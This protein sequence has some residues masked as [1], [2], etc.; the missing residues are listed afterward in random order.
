M[1][2][3]AAALGGC[4][5]DTSQ[6]AAGGGAIVER[7]WFHPSV[8]H[9]AP[10]LADVGWR[11]VALPDY[12]GLARRSR[13][14]SGWY[15]IE[16]ARP[17]GAGPWAASLHGDWQSLEVEIG[18]QRLLSAD[19]PSSQLGDRHAGV[20]LPLLD[21]AGGGR[22]ITL[23]FETAP[24]R[25]GYLERAVIGP[26]EAVVALHDRLAMLQPTLRTSFAALAAACGLLLALLARW[27]PT[28]GA[29]WFAA[30]TIV[31]S[32][33]FLQPSAWLTH[34]GDGFVASF[35]VHVFPL[36]FVIGLHR[37]LALAR[38][39]R[40]RALAVALL[41]PGVVRLAVPPVLVPLVDGIWWLVPLGIGFYLL[42]LIAVA[43]KEG[44]VERSRVLFVGTVVC[45]AAGIHDLASLP[46][47]GAPAGIFL[48]QFAPGVLA[49]CTAAMLLASLGWRLGEA[50]R[51]NV[52]LED[53]V[54]ARRR[55]LASSYARMAELEGDRAIA[56]ER[57]RLMRDMHDGTGGAL[58]SAIAMAEAGGAP[59]A[60]A[61][62]LRDALA[63]LRLSIDSLDPSEHDL[64][65]LLGAARARLAPR[66]EGRAARIAWEVR[67]VPMPADFGPA[68]ALQVLRIFQ[69]AIVNA[70]R[71]AGASTVTVRTDVEKDA[72]ARTWIAIVVADDGRG[73][74][75]DACAP[76]PGGGRGLGNMRRRAAALGGD[77]AIES[78]PGGTRVRL[79]LPV[80][81]DRGGPVTRP[82]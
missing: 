33:G 49:L 5:L 71:H 19:A 81:E 28:R 47:G 40:E 27:D 30:G 58:V 31:W 43:A 69:E 54:E 78:G 16:F 60:V 23:R 21:T 52:E 4:A 8:S 12:W 39:R 38:P 56:A 22:S 10:A 13:G 63:D 41:A 32:A 29:R 2:L 20:F 25:I 59:A 6:L 72:D 14:L 77:L 53:R 67:E 9:S 18:G 82:S 26:S 64:A 66:F 48:F 36:F 61:E 46:L 1:L 65:S 44:R 3:A 34:V 80:A 50:Q 57:E 11:E 74:D 73:F 75:V 35:C 55:E 37:R 42:R 70:M 15:R 17:D 24:S 62:V 45:L 76:K 79:R 7:A 68:S 51:L